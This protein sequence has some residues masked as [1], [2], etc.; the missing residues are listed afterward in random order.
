MSEFKAP[1]HYKLINSENYLINSYL[2][3]TR[4]KA[5]H[6]LFIFIEILLNIFLELDIFVKGFK[7]GN[8]SKANFNFNIISIIKNKFDLLE[9]PVHLLIVIFIIVVFDLLY[10]FVKLKKIKINH[11]YIIIIINFLELF[12]FRVCSLILFNIFFTLKKDSN[13]SS[14]FNF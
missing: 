13:I 12:F 14:L 5:I 9:P 8:T 11:I 10:I 6:F 1:K 7:M 4:I 3:L 2:S